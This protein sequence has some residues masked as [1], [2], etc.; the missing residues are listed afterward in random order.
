M[1]S[2]AQSAP[3]PMRQVPTQEDPRFDGERLTWG[4]RFWN[5]Q[6]DALR[7]RDRQIEE[8][9]RMLC[10]QQHLVWNSMQQRFVDVSH[11]M[12]D[13][14]RRWR[15]RPV[16]NR[17]L[18]WYLQ[19]HARLVENPPILTF[20]PGP[21]QMDAEL[22]E[23]MD[24]VFKAV[25][26]DIGM[27]DVNDRMMSWLI[28]A[29]QASVLTRVDLTRGPIRSWTGEAPLTVLG[30]D[31]Q[32]ML[33]QYGQPMTETR[34]DVPF[35]RDG[36]ALA[37]IDGS[38]GET[39]PYGAAHFDREG[40][41]VCDVLNPLQVRGQW[42]D[43]PWHM[44]NWHAYIDYFT[45]EECKEHWGVEVD[46]DDGGIQGQ[47]AG[48]LQR[49]MFGAGYYGAASAKLGADFGAPRSTSDR[50]VE[51][52]T[53]Y[54]AP[55]Q[56][57]TCPE[58]QETPD[59]P[60]GRMLVMSRKKVFS[61]QV[62]PA[63][64]RYTSP[65]R[66]WEFIRIPGRP[67]GSTPQ[68]IINAPQRAYNRRWA[69]I[70]EQTQLQ[71]HPITIVDSGSG[72]DEAEITNAPG[73]KFTVTRRPG[74]PAIEFVAPPAL[75]A[76][77]YK[78]LQML[79]DEIE[80]AGDLQGTEGAP[81][82]RDASGEL[83]KELR[84]NSD[85][86]IGPTARRAVEEYGRL[87]EDWMVM[88]PILWDQPKILA[89][90]GEDHVAQTLTVMPDLLR[91]GKVNVLPDVESM[92]PEG[93]GERQE[94]VHQMYTEGMFGPQG[95]PEAVKQY[96]EYA[97]FSNLSRVARPGGPHRVMAEHILGRLVAGDPSAV[98]QWLPWYNPMIHMDV[99]TDFVAGPAFERCT[100]ASQHLLNGRWQFLNAIMGGYVPPNPFTGDQDVAVVL[101]GTP[102]TGGQQQ[103][104][105]QPQVNSASAAPLPG[106]SAPLTGVMESPTSG[107]FLPGAAQR[108]PNGAPS[109]Y[110][111][112]WPGSPP[113]K[114]ATPFQH[115]APVESPQ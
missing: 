98:Q 108:Q 55:A 61:D 72:L 96:L 100:G 105:A 29:G 32:P 65:I 10:G 34:P 63:R 42:G 68:E 89:Y 113:F 84:F 115:L 73:Q 38:T 109:P 19:T 30:P 26:R 59:S 91:G 104:L 110:P 41:M 88:L 90:A 92:L 22:A 99:L 12:T 112:S 21:D 5:S 37:Y 31:M 28:V 97:N 78:A 70:L 80:S 67:S 94:R 52:L 39:V 87:A 86:Y 56:Y 25:W 82:S 66:T 15:Q 60:G 75:G 51:V 49:L 85:R 23:T 4:W 74:V 1:S 106:N 16:F 79:G 44:K 102:M 103:P 36:G 83:V 45:P 58:M 62:R 18:R 69:S 81:P 71:A 46:A 14:E 95:S 24:T 27:L 17:L 64:W 101:P 7:L 20:V 47:S 111:T 114:T 3:P 54:H 77:T 40:E 93:R 43:R 33:D 13:E 57:D 50:Y 76:D 6:T 35:D 2:T 48:E 107:M 53:L 11:W 8:N 9:V